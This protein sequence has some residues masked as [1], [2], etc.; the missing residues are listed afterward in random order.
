LRYLVL[1]LGYSVA[2]QAQDW[3]AIDRQLAAA[4]KAV[5]ARDLK[6]AM[7][8]A[9]DLSRLT[10][11]EYYKNHRPSDYLRD[12]EAK[13]VANPAGRGRMLPQIAVLAAQ[14][15]EWEKA[16]R[17]ALDAFVTPS[18][19]D[20]PAHIANNVL[21]LVALHEGNVPAAETYLRAAGRTKGS[22]TLK[23]WGPMLALAKALLDK[24]RNDVV[25]EYFE[26]CKSFVT[27][28]K[29]LDIWIATLKG[30][31]APDLSREYLWFQ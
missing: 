8:K 5:E 2:A 19:I 21:G 28:N 24:G 6:A 14:S 13:I 23:R 15:E 4:Q 9:S 16:R 31:A 20:D 7:D 12:W 26:A 27:E 25:L 3:A 10:S 22:Q 30:G 18:P 17:Y 1:L 11:T 29:N